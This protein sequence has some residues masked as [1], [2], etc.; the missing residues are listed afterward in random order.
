MQ[1]ITFVFIF[2]SLIFWACQSGPETLPAAEDVAD[3]MAYATTGSIEIKD[4]AF[5]ELIDPAA[6][7]EVLAEGFV[8]SEGPL[9][10]PEQELL[11]FSD[12]PRNT[13]YSW[14]EGDRSAQV[15]LRPSGFTGERTESGEPGSNGLV[16]SPEGR[17]VLCQHGDRRVA[18]MDMPDGTPDGQYETLAATFA[19]KRFSSPN[20]AA[21]HPENGDLYFTDPPYGLAGQAD[22]P[23]K[24]LAFNGVFRLAADGTVSVMDERV[25]RPNGIAFNPDGQYAYVACSDPKAAHYYRYTVDATGNFTDRELFFDATPM[26]AD[27]PGL[28]DGLKVND[29]GVI[30]ATGP[31]GVLVFSP[32]GQHIGTINTGRPTANCAF[33]PDQKSLFMTA[34]DVLLRVALR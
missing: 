16:L 33:G 22:S 34:D 24:E 30:F 2:L 18:V 27:A 5:K 3:A 12:V 7:I 25:T 13:V 21:F 15:Y 20:D 9:W 26:V 28:P 14:K 8:W 17:L 29:Q 23:D 31:G 6:A 19:G 1:Q 4:Q 32:E 11:I 10:L